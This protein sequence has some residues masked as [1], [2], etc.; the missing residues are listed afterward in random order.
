MKKVER[1]KLGIVI[2]I[3]VAL[4]LGSGLSPMAK[5]AMAGALG[6]IGCGFLIDGVWG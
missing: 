4:V 6:V 2:F 1:I 5:S 3:V